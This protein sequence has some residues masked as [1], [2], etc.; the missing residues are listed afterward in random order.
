M[1]ACEGNELYHEKQRL[2]HCAIHA[3]NNLFQQDW[4]S[5]SDFTAIAEDLH[6]AD[7]S[8]GISGTFTFNPYR[9]VLPYIGNFDI[10][11]IV[12]ALQTKGC[13]ISNHIALSASLSLESLYVYDPN[14]IGYV[15]NEEV[16]SLFGLR[17]SNH[18]IAVLRKNG[19]FVNLD[20][21]L[22][23]PEIIKSEEALVKIFKIGMERRKWQVFVVSREVSVD[24]VAVGDA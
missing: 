18:W 17:K 23:S 8:T 21:E 5:Y 20:A 9:S 12:H 3:L 7:K 11:C 15:I 19:S 4:I 2:A 1:S 14:T 13:R 24:S 16:R 6:S 10:Q 22:T